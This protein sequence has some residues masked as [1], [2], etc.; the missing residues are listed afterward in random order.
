MRVCAHVHM[1]VFSVGDLLTR[2]KTHLCVLVYSKNWQILS[3][4]IKKAKQIKFKKKLIKNKILKI[5]NKK[6]KWSQTEYSFLF[7]K[8]QKKKKKKKI[9][10]LSKVFSRVN[11]IFYK[12]Y[13]SSKIC[14]RKNMEGNFGCI[15]CV[16]YKNIDMSYFKKSQ[17]IVWNCVC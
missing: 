3:N 7:F 15:W 2:I 16:L 12:S 5:H 4:H 14:K 13:I 10:L 11:S 17:M 8:F 9:S 1:W 6:P